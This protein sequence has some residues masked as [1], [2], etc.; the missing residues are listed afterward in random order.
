M[1]GQRLAN[2]VPH[3]L[4]RLDGS[5]RDRRDLQQQGA[6][7]DGGVGVDDAEAGKAEEA[8]RKVACPI[9]F[10]SAE[11]QNAPVFFP[12]VISRTP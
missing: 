8:A 11:T 9:C 10:C 1:A 4:L 2:P 3:P 7:G 5:R 6:G 12:T